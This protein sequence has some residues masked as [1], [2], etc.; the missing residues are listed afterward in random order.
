MASKRQVRR[1][2]CVGKTRHKSKEDAFAA[3]KGHE[4]TFNREKL[5]PYYCR[6]C[7]GWHIGHPK[8]KPLN[9]KNFKL[10]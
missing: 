4:K 1:K 5:L 2:Q 10:I 9:R 8:Q 7:Q 3:S 6:F